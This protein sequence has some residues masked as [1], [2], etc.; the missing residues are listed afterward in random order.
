MLSALAAIVLVLMFPLLTAGNAAA[1]IRTNP[2]KIVKYLPPRPSFLGLHV[3]MTEDSAMLVMKSVA[4]RSNKLPADSM[5][6][7][8]TDSVNIFGKPAYLQLQIVGRKVRTIV[9]NFHPMGGGDYLALRDQ[10]DQYLERYFGRGVILTNESITYHRWETE[11]GTSEVSHS[12]KYL[13]I[14]VRLGKPR[15]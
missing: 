2:A 6:L 3:G 4:K 8:E 10:L 7:V 13:R 9:I 1:Q 14:F 5:T 15:V 11:D 12:D